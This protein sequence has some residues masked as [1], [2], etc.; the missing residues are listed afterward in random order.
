MPKPLVV[1][2]DFSAGLIDDPTIPARSG[3]QTYDCID[4]ITTP[5]S[6]RAELAAEHTGAEIANLDDFINS[7]T[8]Y[9]GDGTDR[10]LGITHSTKKVFV[11]NNSGVFEVGNTNTALTGT[12]L[13]AGGA[14][15]IKFAGKCY[16]SATEENL[17]QIDG[18]ALLTASFDDTFKTFTNSDTR[19][20]MRE[21]AGL[22]CITD[23][24]NI[25]TL[26]PDHTT[27]NGTALTLPLGYKAM[28][29]EP[30]GDFL[31]IGTKA[32]VSSANDNVGLEG[33]AKVF[34]WDGVS[35]DASRI[36]DVGI[37]TGV[38]AMLTVNNQLYVFTQKKTQ[39]IG[40][41]IHRFNGSAF[42]IVRTIRSQESGLSSGMGIFA[43]AVMPFN[44]DILMG[45]R[46]ISGT[47]LKNGVYALTRPD[48]NSPFALVLK[49]KPESA[50]SVAKLNG[51]IAG[52]LTTFQS[53]LYVSW[54]VNDGAGF[55]E[56]SVDHIDAS[57]SPYNGA[58]WESQ[59]YENAAFQRVLAKGVRLVLP[60]IPAGSVDIA[61][62]LDN[63]AAWTSLGTI[64]S[65]NQD[66]IYYGIYSRFKTIQIQLTFNTSGANTPEVRRIEIY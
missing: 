16:C 41:N 47:A 11:R 26:D 24:R 64:T 20:I 66:D 54:N 55:D 56:D 53:N 33:F 4:V 36:I 27:F 30:F 22:L 44:G 65:T 58:V 19:H 8:I 63:A 15:I 39:P 46:S 31:A 40:V 59:I 51:T 17:V 38:T 45:T 35:T 1:I 48:S 23:G 5:G 42:D 18:D 43:N 9:D 2:D 21:F 25:A 49:A 13:T 52:A 61:Y 10:I 6:A 12:A 57:S 50:D 62:K 28:C 3:G 60:P 14:D 37:E 7:F 32:V 34:L 29:I